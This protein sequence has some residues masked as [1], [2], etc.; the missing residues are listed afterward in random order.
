MHVF[1]KPR[2]PVEPLVAPQGRN[3]GNGNGPGTKKEAERALVK[4]QSSG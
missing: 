2:S 4:A 1:G 3:P